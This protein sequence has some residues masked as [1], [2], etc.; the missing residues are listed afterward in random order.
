MQPTGN[1]D[2]RR[3]SARQGAQ[4][5]PPESNRIGAATPHDFEGKNPTA[6]GGLLP[7]AMMLEKLGFKQLV[8][9]TLTVP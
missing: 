1:R 7:I 8:E 3:D 9:E 5:V 2:T 6:Y 4:D